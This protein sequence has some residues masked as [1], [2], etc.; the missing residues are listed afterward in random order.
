MS[1][2]RPEHCLDC[3]FGGLLAVVLMITTRR[4]EIITKAVAGIDLFL[5]DWHNSE[6]MGALLQL[7]GVEL[8][9]FPSRKRYQT[10][11]VLCSSCR[12]ARQLRCLGNHPN[13]GQSSG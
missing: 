12:L 13:H 8:F 4:V 5:E 1:R 11:S 3:M 9:S 6:Y 10:C 7:V 2:H